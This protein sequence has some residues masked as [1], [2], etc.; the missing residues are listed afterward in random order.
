VSVSSLRVSES[1]QSDRK[2]TFL[3]LLGPTRKYFEGP[4]F[5]NID[6]TADDVVL[7]ERYGFEAEEVPERFSIRKRMDLAQAFATH[8]KRRGMDEEN[9]MLACDFPAGFITTPD[10]TPVR[11]RVQAFFA[12]ISP[13]VPIVIR[14]HAARPFPLDIWG[15]EAEAA[16]LRWAIRKKLNITVS[17]EQNSGKTAC[18]NSMLIDQAEA[19]PRERSI[20]LQDLDELQPCSRNTAVLFYDVEQTR[21]VN[22]RP[23]P[24][25]LRLQDLLPH[26]LRLRTEALAIGET[27]D[28]ATMV[29]LVA[30]ANTGTRGTKTTLHANSA[31]NVFD[32]IE[33]MIIM[34]GKPPVRSAIAE[35]AQVIVHLAIDPITRKRRIDHILHTQGV[36]SGEYVTDTIH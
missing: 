30:A 28:P 5:I 10:G 33:W 13:G 36:E 7:V 9:S 26:A 20:I 3:N 24:Y 27:R 4:D 25:I 8:A 18:L 11:G 16:F 17:G 14:K 23:E 32:R 31:R 22:G 19:F 12:P 15:T 6:M 2:R 29:G 21:Y 35:L 34:D 1:T